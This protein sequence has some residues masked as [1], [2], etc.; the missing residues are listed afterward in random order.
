MPPGGSRD[1][2][3]LKIPIN[4]PTKVSMFDINFLPRAIFY[5]ILI[6]EAAIAADWKWGVWGGEAPPM[7]GDDDDGG[8]RIPG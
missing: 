6:L 1:S 4:A 8:G 5:Y 7:E 2:R 3:N